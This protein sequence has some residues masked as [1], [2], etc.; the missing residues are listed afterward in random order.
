MEQSKLP[1][2]ICQLNNISGHLLAVQPAVS[3]ETVFFRILEEA[4]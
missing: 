3:L 2:A 4:N 1:E